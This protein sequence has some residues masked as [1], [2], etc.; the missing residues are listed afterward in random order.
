MRTPNCECVICQ[1]PMYRRPGDLARVRYV[2]CYTHR[3][4]AKRRAGVTDKQAAALTLGR[5][6]GTNHRGGYRHREDSKRKA[7][8][9][10]KAWCAANPDRVLARASKLRGENHYRWAGGVS[11]LNLSIRQ[12]TENRRWMDAVK[13]RDGCC[14]RCGTTRNLESHHK[15]PFAEILETYSIKSRDDARRQAAV[16][17]DLENGE[18]LCMSCH[19]DEH[20]RARREAA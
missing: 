14:V 1:K 8:D 6:K 15:T 10:H 17:W 12:M 19:D 9:S 3:E 16:L 20:G 2:A 5:V 7:S 4:E 18:T 13:G 11:Q